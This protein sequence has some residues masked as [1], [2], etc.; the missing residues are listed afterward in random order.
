LIISAKVIV[1]SNDVSNAG[2]LRLE[3]PDELAS[4]RASI[5]GSNAGRDGSNVGR[6]NVGCGGLNAGREGATASI[7]TVGDDGAG[8]GAISRGLTIPSISSRAPRSRARI[9]SASLSPIARAPDR[10]RRTLTAFRPI[11]LPSAPEDKFN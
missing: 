5:D 1:P 4:S 2:S 10:Q 3:A 11:S 6:E 7:I 9:A 8:K